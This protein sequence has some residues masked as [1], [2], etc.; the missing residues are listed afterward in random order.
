MDLSPNQLY[1]VS[2]WPMV[3][4]IV[5]FLF[6]FINLIIDFNPILILR[7]YYCQY[8][9]FTIFKFSEMSKDEFD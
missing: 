1:L 9:V 2:R 3:M 4:H 7:V 8:S 5:R 6:Q